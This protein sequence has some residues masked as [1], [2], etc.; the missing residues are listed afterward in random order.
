MKK[1]IEDRGQIYNNFK[2]NNPFS[3]L[4]ASEQIL[5]NSD[6]IYLLLKNF[7]QH[8]VHIYSLSDPVIREE[9]RILNLAL[10]QVIADGRLITVPEKIRKNKKKMIEILTINPGLYPFIDNELKNDIQFNIALLDKTGDVLHDLNEK[11]CANYKVL[12]R[13]CE[14]LKDWYELNNF[15]V[16]KFLSQEVREIVKSNKNLQEIKKIFHQMYLKEDLDCRVEKK[17]IKI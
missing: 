14:I 12:S 10:G 15:V 11:I 8:A 1:I 5:K 16:R 3:L 17:S 9:E 6:F 4:S 2:E 13:A 7:P